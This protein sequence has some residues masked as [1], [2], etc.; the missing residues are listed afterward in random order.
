MK[1]GNTESAAMAGNFDEV[2]QLAIKR[3]KN[4]LQAEEVSEQ[5]LSGA[6]V[7][8]SVLSAYTRY[9]QTDSA[10]EAT[11]FMMARELAQNPEDFR[12]YLAVACPQVPVH[13]MIEKK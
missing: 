7:A 1:N 3:L 4:F 10:R 5:A 12:R 6:R 13:A 2:A 8:A 11:R 9:Q